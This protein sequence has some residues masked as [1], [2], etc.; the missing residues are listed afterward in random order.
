[1]ED[2]VNL[3]PIRKSLA[4]SVSAA[5]T[6]L[7]I[8]ATPAAAGEV[9]TVQSAAVGTQSKTIDIIGGDVLKINKSIA[10]TYRFQPG[11]AHVHQGDTI[12]LTNHSD[13]FHTF[14]L[15]DT[16][17]LPTTAGD[18]FNCGA[19]GTICGAVFADHFPN[20]F[21]QGPPAGCP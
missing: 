16:S 4:I 20:G 11:N 21:P 2:D 13:D 3:T 5:V 15:V 17:L 7:L 10:S 9:S 1:M 18:V 19:P 8:L 12:V 6:S 14:S